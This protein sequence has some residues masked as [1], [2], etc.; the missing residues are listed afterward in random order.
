MPKSDQ[1]SSDLTADNA[2]LPGGQRLELLYCSFV[3]SNVHNT[4]FFFFATFPSNMG[5]LVDDILQEAARI[6]TRSLHLVPGDIIE[7]R[8][9]S[10][11][12]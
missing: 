2:F 5:S 9:S 4:I 11:L 3:L 12:T 10:L 6:F 8:M 7:A 1:S